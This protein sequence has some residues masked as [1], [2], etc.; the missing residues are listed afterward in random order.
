M[1]LLPLGNSGLKVSRLSLGCMSYGSSQARPWILD[2]EATL[3]FYRQ[4]IDVGIN[5]FDTA[6]LYSQGKSEEVTGRAL[7]KLGVRRGQDGFLTKMFYSTRTN[8]NQ[9]GTSKKHIPPAIPA[10]LPGPCVD[11]LE[12]YP[13]HRH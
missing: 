6:D 13:M 9:N 5:F 3:P 10:R 8:P 4:A 11:P 7:K 12:L 1:I 2:E